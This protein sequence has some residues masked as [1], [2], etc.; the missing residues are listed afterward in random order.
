MEPENQPPSTAVPAAKHTESALTQSP[1]EPAP[2]EPAPSEEPYRGL[3]WIFIGSQ[4]LRAGWS[5]LIFVFLTLFLLRVLG[6]AAFLFVH[7]VLHIKA[8]G[9]TPISAIIGGLIEVLAILGA[10]AMA[11]LIERR[12][13]LDYNL[14]GPRRPQHFLFGLVSGFIALSA[15]IGALAAGGW[16]HFGPVELSGKQ[17]FTFAALWGGAFLLTALFEEGSFRCYLQFT[18]TR[19]INFWWALGVIA[20]TCAY[21]AIFVGGSASWGVYA[22]ALLGLFPCLILNQKS[23]PRSGFWCAAWVS[24]TLFGFIHVGNPNEAWIGIFAAAF[25]GFVFCVSVR[26]TGS[27][28]WAIGCHASWDWGETYFYGTADSGITPQGSYLTSSPAGNPLWSGGAVG[29]EGSL[30][31][32]GAIL[33]LLA[34]VLVYGRSSTRLQSAPQAVMPLP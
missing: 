8:G 13:I 33:F 25:I 34:L 19:G 14:T 4:G 29:P 22:A 2:A 18:F 15:L 23:A 32:L 31:V 1:P 26:V 10:G 24:S 5:V 7:R 3:R 17:I 30:L 20:V 27:A 9:F 21:L 11:A 28:W 6:T 12:R 16:L